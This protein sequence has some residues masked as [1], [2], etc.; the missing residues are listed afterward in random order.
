MMGGIA[1]SH[2]KVNGYKKRNNYGHFADS[3][4]LASLSKSIQESK[5]F[6]IS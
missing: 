2:Y 1:N 5:R 4:S 3:Q 6:N